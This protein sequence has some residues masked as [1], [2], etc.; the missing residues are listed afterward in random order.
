MSMMIVAV[1]SVGV[2]GIIK[3]GAEHSLSERQH[4]TMR[5]MALGLVEDLRRDLRT[6]DTVNNLG[7]GSNQLVINGNGGT[8]TYTLNTGNH[9][10]T[11]QANGI[12]RIYNDPNVYLSNME[13]SC[14]NPNT[15]QTTTCF[16]VDPTAG[17]AS[18]GT[19]KAVYLPNVTVT[20]ALAPGNSGTAIDQAFGAPS[21]KL[22]QFS[23]N[24]AAATEFQ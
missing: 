17:T 20:A 4:Q 16:Q 5:Q 10:M 19:P 15:N 6:A 22:N 18:N 14:V 23:F 24:I 9:Q 7:G 2:S 13:F 12:T 1:L 21:F 8:I 11:R 3:A